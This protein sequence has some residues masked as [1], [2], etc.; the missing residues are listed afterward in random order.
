MFRNEADRYGQTAG[1]SLRFYTA[2]F[3][4]TT[5]Y[6]PRRRRKLFQRYFINAKSKNCR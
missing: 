6:A 2:G 4:L 3:Y 1:L 5:A